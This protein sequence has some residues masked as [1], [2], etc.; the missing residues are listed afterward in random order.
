MFTIDMVDGMSRND[1]FG[2]RLAENPKLI[3]A[4]WLLLLLTVEVGAVAA[5]GGASTGGP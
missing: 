1:A 5:G 3:H 4:A 2:N